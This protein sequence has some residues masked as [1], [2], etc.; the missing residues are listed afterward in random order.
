LGFLV[1][2]RASPAVPHLGNTDTLLL[3]GSAILRFLSVGVYPGLVG[4]LPF[5]FHPSST[6]TPITI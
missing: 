6:L 4:A 3:F 2:V 5:L 1:S